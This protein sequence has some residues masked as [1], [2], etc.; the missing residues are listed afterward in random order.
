[1]IRIIIVMKWEK[2]LSH[3]MASLYSHV[4]LSVIGCQT[5]SYHALKLAEAEQPDIAV[6]GYSLDHMGGLDFIPLIRGKCPGAGIILISPY[7][8][9]HYARTALFRGVSGYLLR[10]F[11]M[12]ILAWA[13]CLVFKG[14]SYISSHIVIRIFQNLPDH[15]LGRRVAP[16][17][18]FWESTARRHSF[19]SETDWQIIELITR[20][21]TTK[22][23]AE[24][25][26]LKIGTV[27]NYISVMMR[28]T[29]SGNRMQI[30]RFAFG[31]NGPSKNSA[32]NE[33]P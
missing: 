23:I 11:D 3:V 15:R 6:I 16:F 32:V 29:G 27:R 22:E 30:A 26:D 4:G 24:G 10:K 18:M 31:L 20:G 25:L 28:K 19:F 9:P 7:D 8:D 33:Q 2:E 5:D 21:K 13:I 17:R 12:H 14:G 1:M